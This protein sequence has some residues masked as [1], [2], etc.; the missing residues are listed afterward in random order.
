[1][2]G[3]ELSVRRPLAPLIVERSR[4]TIRFSTPSG[5]LRTWV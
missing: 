2:E 1:M 5:L 3:R 4:E